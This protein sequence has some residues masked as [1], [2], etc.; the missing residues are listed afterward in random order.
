MDAGRMESQTMNAPLEFAGWSRISFSAPFLYKRRDQA[1]RE[2]GCAYGQTACQG[3]Y[4]LN[5]CEPLKLI[6]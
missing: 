1:Q 6:R 5:V 3:C 4:G 2:E